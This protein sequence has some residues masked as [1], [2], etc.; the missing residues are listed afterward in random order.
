MEG[1]GGCRQVRCLCSPESSEIGDRLRAVWPNFL[2]VD[3]PRR[4]ER[5][6]PMLL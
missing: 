3:V 2:G 4:C 5:T 6:A 1:D